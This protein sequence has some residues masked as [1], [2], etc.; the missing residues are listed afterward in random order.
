VLEGRARQAFGQS[1][2][3]REERGRLLA[4]RATRAFGQSLHRRADRLASL[5]AL[6]RSLGPE[7]VL[8]RGYALVRDEAG[9]LLR[10]VGEAH[11]GRALSVQL[12]DGSFGVTVAGEG[13]PKPAPRPA[14]KG[15]PHGAQGDL[16]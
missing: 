2:V 9:A 4:E 16:F 13:G 15:P 10:S 6:I 3:Q 8:A 14:R 7:A 11:P 5:W 1:L 12:A